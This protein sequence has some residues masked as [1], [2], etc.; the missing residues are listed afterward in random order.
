VIVIHAKT[1]YVRE[2]PLR[3]PTFLPRFIGIGSFPNR[4]SFA[5]LALYLQRSEL[6]CLE[7]S[8]LDRFDPSRSASPELT[9]T[10]DTSHLLLER[11]IQSVDLKV[12]T[13]FPCELNGCFVVVLRC[14]GA[15]GCRCLPTHRG[16]GY[17]MPVLGN[18]D[19]LIG[20]HLFLFFGD[21]YLRT[22]ALGNRHSQYYLFFRASQ[23]PNNPPVPSFLSSPDDFA[24]NAVEATL[25]LFFP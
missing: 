7:R 13:R 8:S 10:D 5:R 21:L 12:D 4:C 15:F 19:T 6:H 9:K 20:S 16:P 25:F 3:A 14:F 1:I 17:R 22:G 2:P 18:F 24:G 23:S 11:P